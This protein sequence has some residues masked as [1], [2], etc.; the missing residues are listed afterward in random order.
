MTSETVSSGINVATPM[1]LT[2]TSVM[3]LKILCFYFKII[4]S[5]RDY[6]RAR[7]HCGGDDSRSVRGSQ[8]GDCHKETDLIAGSPLR[9]DD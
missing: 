6:E 7:I 9:V 4:Y 5:T 8:M 1:I 2:Q 3:R